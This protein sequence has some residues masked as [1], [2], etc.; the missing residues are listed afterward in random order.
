VIRLVLNADDLGLTAPLSDA[1]VRLRAD[2]LVTDTSLLTCGEAF[3]EAASALLAQGLAT[4]GIHLCVV[5]GESPV[6]SP[7]DVPSLL[8]GGR[9]RPGWPSVA[10]AAAAGRIR[11]RDVEREWE[12]QIVR[13]LE[14]G[15][16]VDHLDSHQHLHLLPTFLP[17]V[18][19][20][21]RRFDVAYVRAPGVPAGAERTSAGLGAAGKVK[22]LSAFGERAR[23]MLRTIGLPD[24]PV[25]IGLGEAGRMTLPRWTALLSTLAPGTYEV[26][27]HPGTAAGGTDLRYRWGYRWDEEAQALAGLELR[28]LFARTGVETT[29]FSGLATVV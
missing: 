12:A 19:R 24:P 15:L 17:V 3:A 26:V 10:A 29:S 4:T 22:L 8:R 9:F 27:L 18:I 7:S 2:G 23:R 14:A 5:G 20:L 13:A 16:R 1:I 21:A 11:V 28:T 25:A 6:S